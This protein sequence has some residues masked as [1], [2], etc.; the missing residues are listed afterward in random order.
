MPY[1]ASQ[2]SLYNCVARNSYC[3]SR[4]CRSCKRCRE[5]LL[6]LPN[7]IRGWIGN[8][9]RA[10]ISCQFDTPSGSAALDLSESKRPLFDKSECS[11]IGSQGRNKIKLETGFRSRTNFRTAV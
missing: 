9:V 1:R 6:A 4:R 3:P 10:I 11:S 8:F 2:V 5:S 7:L